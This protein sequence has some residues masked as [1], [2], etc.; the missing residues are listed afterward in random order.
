VLD[1][2]VNSS[3]AG[4]RRPPVSLREQ[5]TKDQ[6][7]TVAGRSARWYVPAAVNR[8]RRSYAIGGALAAALSL[9]ACGGSRLDATEP[10]G[11]YPV[12]V[13]SATFPSGQTL[14][15]HS[16]LVIVVRN[17]G[18]KTIPNI[19]VTICNVTCR[20]PAPK[21]EGTSLQP[22]AEP[23]NTPYEANL[24]RQVWVVERS[25]GPCNFGCRPGTPEGNGG[26]GGSI[27]SDVN[28]WALGHALKPGATAKFDW[29]VTA[30]TP[31]RHVVA[32]QIAA[33]LY[34]KSVA[35]G[36]NG[37]SLTG[38]LPVSISRAP[39]QAFVDN[40]GKIVTGRGQ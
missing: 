16:H 35:V 17:P 34:G 38:A 32:W 20:Y 33:G 36:A 29:T 18:S 25:P 5:L 22:F 3:A 12:Q 2:P 11:H 31:G 8:W 24:S 40:S 6:L 27:T 30:V 13:L 26:Q 9:G 10:S 28:T 1:P 4:A 39:E 7:G 21:G 23:N 14:S 19:A 15:Q 37:S